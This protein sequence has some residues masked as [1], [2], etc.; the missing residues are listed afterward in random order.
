MLKEQKGITLVA[1]VITIIVLLILAGIS[2][3]LALGN[4]GI[5]RN[6][7]I[8]SSAWTQGEAETQ[9]AM[10][11]AACETD[12]QVEKS[13]NSTAI[14][15]DYYTKEK[16]NANMPQGSYD[17]ATDIVETDSENEGHYKFKTSPVSVTVNTPEGTD[18]KTVSVVITSAGDEEVVSVKFSKYQ[19]S[20]TNTTNP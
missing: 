8:S 5:I 7:Q 17:L 15:A 9:L 14:R 11:L 3:S 4:N 19:S 1:L 6:A 16:I 13:D 20:T 12:Y 2:I 10:A 18:N